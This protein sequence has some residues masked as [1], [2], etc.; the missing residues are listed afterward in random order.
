APPDILYC[1]DTDGDGKADV[2]KRIFTGFGRDAAG[3]GMLNSFRWGLDNRFHV[4]TSG[5]GGEV[6]RA[7]QKDAKAV[8]ARRRTFVFDPRTY[9][10]ELT[11]GGGQHGMTMDDWGN[12]FVCANSDPIHYLMY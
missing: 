10:F 11:S 2:V 7:D 12:T 5:A 1:K 3:E 6:R 9:A 8:S 4:A